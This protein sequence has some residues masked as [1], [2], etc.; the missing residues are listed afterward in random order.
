M[1]YL[2]RIL[3]AIIVGGCLIISAM[4][5][6][7]GYFYMSKQMNREILNAFKEQTKQ[8][9]YIRT[10]TMPHV[11]DVIIGGSLDIDGSLHVSGCPG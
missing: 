9:E 10:Q 1:K 2:L 8:I 6:A 11:L 7:N 3:P 5:L 4:I